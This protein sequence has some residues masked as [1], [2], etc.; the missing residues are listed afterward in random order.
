MAAVMSPEDKEGLMK[1]GSYEALSDARD[2]DIHL[3]S[4]L[5]DKFESGIWLLISHSVALPCT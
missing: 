5:Y 3:Y 1:C 4:S 2:E